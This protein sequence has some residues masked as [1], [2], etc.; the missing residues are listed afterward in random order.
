VAGIA[1]DEFK[2]G[3]NTGKSKIDYDPKD[4]CNT[5]RQPESSLGSL[6][7]KEEASAYDSGET[8]YQSYLV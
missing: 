1:V 8:S 7:M 6:V 2:L 5:H 4:Y 3:S